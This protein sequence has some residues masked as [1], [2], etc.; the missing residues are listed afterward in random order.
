LEIL[1][2]ISQI[3]KPKAICFLSYDEY[4]LNVNTAIYEKQ[5]LLRGDHVRA[6]KGIEGS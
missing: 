6:G 1:S 4:R 3:Q 5:V 2:E